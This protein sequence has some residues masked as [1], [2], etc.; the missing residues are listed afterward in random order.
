V[1][2]MLNKLQRMNEK[3]E[4]VEKSTRDNEKSSRQCVKVRS[5]TSPLTLLLCGWQIHRNDHQSEE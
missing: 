3:L 1:A 4:K 2:G 5:M